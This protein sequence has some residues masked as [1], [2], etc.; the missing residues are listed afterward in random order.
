MRD[1]ASDSACYRACII[2][3]LRILECNKILRCRLVIPSQQIVDTACTADNPFL[4][5]RFS[6]APHT[7]PLFSLV[8]SIKSN[9]DNKWKTYVFVST[10][11]AEIDGAARDRKNPHKISLTKPMAP[12]M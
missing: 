5:F 2:H 1:L 6:M 7:I 12:S 9:F 10:E 11:T 4:S 8:F 3:V